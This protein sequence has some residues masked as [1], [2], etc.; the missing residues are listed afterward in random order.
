MQPGIINPS[1]LLR[2]AVSR[3]RSA[4]ALALQFLFLAFFGLRF[5][6]RQT[7]GIFLGGLLGP[8]GKFLGG[9]QGDAAQGVGA[10]VGDDQLGGLLQVDAPAA[11]HRAALAANQLQQFVVVQGGDFFQIE[12]DICAA[13]SVQFS[14]EARPP[15]V[16]AFLVVSNWMAMS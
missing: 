1:G 2:R 8:E 7:L 15:W 5:F 4:H 10:I 14:T 12:P 13:L 16:T 6:A 3:Q 11:H 9:L